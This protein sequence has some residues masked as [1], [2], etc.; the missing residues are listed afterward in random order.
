LLGLLAI[1]TTVTTHRIIGYDKLNF[2]YTYILYIQGLDNSTSTLN[3]HI[4]SLL[5][6]V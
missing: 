1:V 4:H 3:N 5:N 6:Y 2:K